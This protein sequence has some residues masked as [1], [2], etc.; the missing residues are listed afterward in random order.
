MYRDRF[1]FA[2]P[3]PIPPR[4]RYEEPK[5]R[6]RAFRALYYT[7]VIMLAAGAGWSFHSH[8]V[9]AAQAVRA[10]IADE[11][12]H[13]VAGT[14]RACLRHGLGAGEA[15]PICKAAVVAWQGQEVAFTIRPTID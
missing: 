7:G 3:S 9:P 1:H 6:S 13:A 8:L 14:A 12:A 4:I 15:S 2:D 10:V 11:A 5:P